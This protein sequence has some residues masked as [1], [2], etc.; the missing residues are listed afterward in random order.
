MND[1]GHNL[2]TFD[3]H[4]HHLI[5]RQ[6][7][8]TPDRTAV[9]SGGQSLTYACLAGWADQ[10]ATSIR[11]RLRDR[12]PST[13]QPLVGV[14]MDRCLELPVTLL[15]VLKA[16][17]AYVPLDPDYPRPRLEAL[18]ADASPPLIVTHS[19][20]LPR[21]KWLASHTSILCVDEADRNASGMS[22][23][24]DRVNRPAI[25]C[26]PPQSNWPTCSTPRARQALRKG[27]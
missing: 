10:L 8:R 7:A 23:P 13:P 11:G 5:E 14:C 4:L 26:R 25:A 2:T 3:S 17:A 9:V 16:G 21:V 6:A 19:H 20:T 24:D 15:A 18:V 12:D 1:D 22:P 27:P